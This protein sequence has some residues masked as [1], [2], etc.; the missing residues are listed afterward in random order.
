[1]SFRERLFRRGELLALRRGAPEVCPPERAVGEE[2]IRLP[3]GVGGVSSGGFPRALLVLVLSGLFLLVA[4]LL[5][6][7][8]MQ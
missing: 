4:G 5:H 7:L 2:V 8:P 1:M 3:P 6:P